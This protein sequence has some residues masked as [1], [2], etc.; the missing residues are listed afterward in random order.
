MQGVRCQPSRQPE[1]LTGSPF[2]AWYGDNAPEGK[3]WCAFHHGGVGAY[4]D[5]RDA[6]TDCEEKARL[7]ASS[8]RC[9]GCSSASASAPCSATPTLAEC[10][11][12]YRLNV[13]TRP[14]M[15][16]WQ[17]EQFDGAAA[18][19]W[20]R[21]AGH[22]RSLLASSR[23][24]M[25]RWTTFASSC[26]LWTSTCRPAH[27]LQRS[28]HAFLL[29]AALCSASRAQTGFESAPWSCLRASTSGDWSVHLTWTIPGGWLSSRR[30][31]WLQA[32][33]WA[34][35]PLK[36]SL[37]VL[38]GC[39]GAVCMYKRAVRDRGRRR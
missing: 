34:S 33:P 3:L 7:P 9:V 5:A 18:A 26:C 35:K 24:R 14:R 30:Q 23:R 32:A 29:G 36:T 2:P 8:R 31:G 4:L 39:I 28:L 37:R 6:F 27:A 38:C 16:R 12:V 10:H 25:R 20:A 15:R 22:G 11:R 17:A 21:G 19:A 1:Q 13:M